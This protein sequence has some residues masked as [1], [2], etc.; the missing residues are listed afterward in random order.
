MKKINITAFLV[1][2]IFHAFA[3]YPPAAEQEGSTAIHKDDQL[4][5]DWASSCTVERGLMNIANP[6]LG[7]VNYGDEADAVGEA[8][9]NSV[10][11]LGDGGN[12]ILSFSVPL[13]NGQG[14]DFA[15]FENAFDDFF[16]E[17]AFVEVSSDGI[18]YFGFH[19]H[20]LTQTE[21]QID[22]FGQ[23]DP[24]KLNNFAGKY[25]AGYGTPF[26]LSELDGI[27]ELDINHITHIRLTDVVGCIQ[28][29]HT[30]YDSEGNKVNDPWATPFES[31]G[32]D[33]D[34]VGVIHN[35]VNVGLYEV[36][37]NKQL[38]YPNPVL[39]Q[40]HFENSFEKIEIYNLNGKLVFQS[41]LDKRN[42]INLSSL[43]KG[44][45][46]AK[47][48]VENSIKTEKLIKL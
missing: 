46:F 13:A 47:L 24:T 45:Y 26:D 25:R 23:L 10:V 1:F 33:L 15:V 43:A 27:P 48:F 32:F 37:E 41:E 42:S 17:L 22:G 36:Y 38:F 34:A 21:S 4:F 30:S 39:D 18:N 9:I 8:D 20:S 19:S 14:W 5:I 35:V 2:V 16:L 31:G 28:P 6:D 29:E 7:Y 3:Q 11:S 44:V 12:A 40:I